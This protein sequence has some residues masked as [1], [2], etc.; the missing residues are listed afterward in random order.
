M[1]CLSQSPCLR[2]LRCVRPT[3]CPHAMVLYYCKSSEVLR[4]IISILWRNKGFSYS[5][6]WNHSL[7]L[8]FLLF[9]SIGWTGIS[10][11]VAVPPV[12]SLLEVLGDVLVT[13]PADL[14]WH[15]TEEKHQLH[16]WDLLLGNPMR[17]C[18]KS[19]CTRSDV[20]PSGCVNCLFI[21]MGD[22]TA[23]LCTSQP[24]QWP[25]CI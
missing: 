25:M 1:E 9:L 13:V 16:L 21:G 18:S 6:I 8:F 15:E 11:V 14:W 19:C 7:L 10:H 2:Y 4:M 5:C 3:L 24:L 17:E 20:C 23:Y 22:R 12:N